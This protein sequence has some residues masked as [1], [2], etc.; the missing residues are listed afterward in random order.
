MEGFADKEIAAALEVPVVPIFVVTAV[1]SRLFGH[2][3]PPRRW[4][5]SMDP[6]SSPVPGE[7][8]V[9]FSDVGW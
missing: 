5:P 2:P 4:S 8:P 6:V 3:A 1:R 7:W 9:Y